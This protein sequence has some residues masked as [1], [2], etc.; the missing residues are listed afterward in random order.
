M[1]ISRSIIFSKPFPTDGST[2][3]PNCRIVFHFPIYPKTRMSV[4]DELIKMTE[5]KF[6]VNTFNGVY[7]RE[8]IRP[9]STLQ[10]IRGR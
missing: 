7:G 10:G 8:K 5:K 2:Y 4:L 6:L 3:G 1:F 9:H